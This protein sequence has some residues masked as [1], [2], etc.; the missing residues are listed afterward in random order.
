MSAYL[1]HNDPAVF[2]N[3]HSFQPERWLDQEE[4]DHRRDE[5]RSSTKNLNRYL[6]AFGKGSHNCVGSTMAYAMLYKTL[7]TVHRSFDLRIEGG[8]TDRDM[9][10]EDHFVG[11]HRRDAP[12]LTV[13][14]ESLHA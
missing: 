11:L 7:A 14:V 10:Y 9:E 6:V 8:L 3:P 12:R 4:D 13:S 1:Q 2:P 5:N